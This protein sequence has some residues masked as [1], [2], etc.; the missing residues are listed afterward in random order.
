MRIL[1]GAVCGVVAAAVW[2]AQQPLDQRV[3]AFAYDDVEM[4]GRAVSRDENWLAPG[5]AL[6]LL[7]GGL[8]GATYALVAPSLPGPAWLKGP[9]AAVAENTALW[10]LVSGLDR[11]HPAREK[12]PALAGNRRALA[13]ATWRHL[14][15]GLVLGELE[16]RLRP[17]VAADGPTVVET[18]ISQNGHGNIANA[19][20]PLVPTDPPPGSS[21]GR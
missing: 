19:S 18:V 4:L 1:R 20:A 13:Q 15:F 5:L 8:F 6:H 17:T 12:I 10:P 14:V 7:N 9:L 16:R 2:A 21:P 3:F 11:F